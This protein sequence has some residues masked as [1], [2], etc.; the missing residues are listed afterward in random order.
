MWQAVTYRLSRIS[1]VGKRTYSRLTFPF[2]A[3]FLSTYSGPV[4]AG[5]MDAVGYAVLATLVYA[6]VVIVLSIAAFFLCRGIANRRFRAL[7]RVLLLVLIYAPVH[8]IENSGNLSYLPAF[9]RFGLDL[10]G[11]G[12]GP[13]HQTGTQSHPYW[14]AYG[15]ALLICLIVVIVWDWW[16]EINAPLSSSPRETEI[17]PQ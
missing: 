3:A 15:I 17:E 13:S 11:L 14:L 4:A 12:H 5:D 8:S 16:I 1:F 7:L 9:L 6:G 10:N 2:G